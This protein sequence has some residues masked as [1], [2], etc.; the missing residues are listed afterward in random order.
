MLLLPPPNPPVPFPPPPTPPSP[1]PPPTGLD[2]DE[3]HAMTVTQAVL[4]AVVIFL[5]A[6]TIAFLCARNNPRVVRKTADCP[7]EDEPA[8]LAAPAG[9]ALQWPTVAATLIARDALG[10][11]ARCAGR[12]EP[13]Y[14]T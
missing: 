5:S 3:L 11:G 13:T 9:E 2:D 4:L 8:T 12:R 10:G 1:P 7:A 14:Y 6:I